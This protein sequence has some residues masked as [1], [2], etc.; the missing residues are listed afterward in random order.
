M[1]TPNYN[2]APGESITDLD[3][4]RKLAYKLLMEGGSGE[5]VQHWTQGANRLVSALMG[6]M[7]LDR[8]QK[9]D[10]KEKAQYRELVGKLLG[11]DTEQPTPASPAFTST[12]IKPSG[13]SAFDPGDIEM[14][15]GLKTPVQY[16]PD[17]LSAAKTNNINPMLLANVL[18]QESGFNPNAVG[19]VTR[20]GEQARGIAQFMPGTA[21]EMGV[22][23]MNPASAIPGA[24]AYLA[25]NQQRFGSEPL[26]AAA[27]NYGPG[28]VQKVG[29]DIAKM[30]AETRNY[31]ANVAPGPSGQPQLPPG[32]TPAQ[33]PAPP[34]NRAAMIAALMGNRYGAPLGQQIAGAMITNQL[35]PKNPTFGVIGED[36][37]GKKTYGWI[38]PTKRSATPARQ[39][40]QPQARP[41]PGQSPDSQVRPT[42]P[43][44]DP[45]AWREAETKRIQ[46]T[47]A[48]QPQKT[49]TANIVVDTIDRIEK[50]IAGSSWPTSGAVGSWLAKIPGS[51]AH[52]VSQLLETVKANAAFDKLQA[53]RAV[54]P[55]GGALGAVSDR[56]NSLLQAAIGALA[57]S[58]SEGQFKENLAIVKKVYQEVIHGPASG[59]TPPVAAATPADGWQEI[60]GVRIRKKQ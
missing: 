31:V 7:D 49:A 36:E 44:A 28:N 27:Y 2:I 16:Q 21:K 18:K 19:P 34:Q 11:G 5:P 60:D 54:S 38:D 50:R 8:L 26:A 14:Q 6:G 41:A 33:Q 1:A 10:E 52:D 59:A 9:G 42:P 46:A 17:V 51:A 22:D 29:G 45:K 55:T 37:Y 12:P 57:Q 39:P 15:A 43:G 25:Q 23:P 32:A 56:E 30:P 48:A 58:Q 4:K 24:A 35:T 53:M 20:S 47:A 3:Y 13:P 40:T